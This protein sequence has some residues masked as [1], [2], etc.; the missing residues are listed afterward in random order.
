[1]EPDK[2]FRPCVNILKPSAVR[3][4]A[5]PD[6][7][8]FRSIVRTNAVLVMDR[9]VVAQRATKD[10][11][12]NQTMLWQPAVLIGVRVIGPVDDDVALIHRPFADLAAPRNQR[13]S[14][15]S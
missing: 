3:V 14:I 10:F 4:V 5:G 12:H 6:F 13:V 9:L 11:R 7:Q 8:I 1:M 15:Q 2:L